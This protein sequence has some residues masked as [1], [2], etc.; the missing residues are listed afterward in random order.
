MRKT[1]KEIGMVKDK[2]QKRE[3]KVKLCLNEENR[4][5]CKL[6]HTKSRNAYKTG[7]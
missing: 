6:R 3:E 4:D 2:Y 1:Q 7:H 5:D